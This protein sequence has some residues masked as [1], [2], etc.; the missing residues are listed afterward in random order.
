MKSY[1]GKRC[2]QASGYVHVRVGEVIDQKTENVWS[3][4]LVRW[5]DNEDTTW[6][7]I[8]NVCFSELPKLE[9]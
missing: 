5:D 7:K 2:W 4:L 9:K 8:L 6:E 3:L 1:I